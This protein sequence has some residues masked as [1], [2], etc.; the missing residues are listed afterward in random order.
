[1]SDD[2]LHSQLLDII[3][4][5]EMSN[6]IKLAK[7]DMLIRL[8]VDVNA[9]SVKED[10]ALLVATAVGNL[11]IVEFL[12]EKGAN[13]NATS[14]V[15]FDVSSIV[16]AC[17]NGYND[18]VEFLIEKG[19]RVNVLYSMT[20]SP[21]AMAIEYGHKNVVETLIKNGARVNEP[22]VFP[23]VYV[24]NL[25]R[26]IKKDNKDIVEILIKNGAKVNQQDAIG[27]TPL[28]D[29]ASKTGNVEIIKLLIENGADVNIKNSVGK[30]AL[31]VAKDKKT[32]KA[33]IDAV[34]ERKVKSVIFKVKKCF[35]GKGKI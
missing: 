27:Y 16:I 17:Q 3:R 25:V 29:A 30:T 18:I 34:K 26:A 22:V 12:V 4:N 13:V 19:A 35:L 2:I 21:L 33:I 10:H 7:I 8:G 15:G 24:S 1:M 23:L 14:S 5:K 31:K 11:P 20:N 28:M 6:D 9:K 32:Q